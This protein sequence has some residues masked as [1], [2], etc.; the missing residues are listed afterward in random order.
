MLSKLDPLG[1]QRSWPQMLLTFKTR[2]AATH[3]ELV[4]GWALEFGLAFVVGD[5]RCWFVHFR[6]I[7]LS[8]RSYYI[9]VMWT[10][11]NGPPSS[12]GEQILHR[13]GG[14]G[15]AKRVWLCVR[16]CPRNWLEKRPVGCVC[17]N[18][19]EVYALQCRGCVAAYMF[20]LQAS[21]MHLKVRRRR[22]YFAQ[23]V[24]VTLKRTTK[25]RA[26]HQEYVSHDPCTGLRECASDRLSAAVCC[27]SICTF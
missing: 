18:G 24:C 9:T 10:L 22:S 5:V 17:E 1:F 27:T 14:Q 21:P 15:Q 6:G 19:W 12:E 16:N 25:L 8:F 4:E 26:N 2:T 11:P 3:G 7:T 20:S 23:Q 13:C